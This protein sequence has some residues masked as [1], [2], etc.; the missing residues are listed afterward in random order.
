MVGWALGSG[1]MVVAVLAAFRAAVPT[2]ADAAR[3]ALTLEPFARTFQ[4][5]LG[6]AQAL[7]TAGGFLTWRALGVLPVILSIYGILLATRMTLGEERR[8]STDLVLSTPV[9]RDAL[10]AG[11]GAAL[12]VGSLAI[13][14]GGMV[15]GWLGARAMGMEIG[16]LAASG[17]RSQREPGHARL[18]V[19]GG[20]S[21]RNSPGAAGSPGR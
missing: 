12:A 13:G 15:V 5:L 16:A 11:Q 10:V 9:S 18:G 19:P 14:V 2:P 6:K 8:G 3:F 7:D 20:S 4:V 1:L 21:W 17:G